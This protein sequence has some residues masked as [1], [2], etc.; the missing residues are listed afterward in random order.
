MTKG[1]AFKSNLL[2]ARGF[3]EQAKKLGPDPVTRMPNSVDEALICCL[4]HLLVA[5]EDLSEMK[6]GG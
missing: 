4:E 1:E 6:E 5:L 2:G 3:L